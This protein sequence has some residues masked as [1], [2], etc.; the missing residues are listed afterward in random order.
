[1]CGWNNRITTGEQWIRKSANDQS[2]PV[3]PNVDGKNN[4]NGHYLIVN[5]RTI[6]TFF[7]VASIRSN[8]AVLNQFKRAYQS[9]QM[10]FHYFIKSVTEPFFNIMIKS[11]ISSYNIIWRLRGDQGSQ[12]KTAIVSIYEQRRPF[13]IKIE[14]FSQG[15]AG[16][17]AIDDIG[18]QNCAP[19]AGTKT[20][21]CH[22]NQKRCQTNNVC[23][24]PY[25]F[26][27]GIDDCGDAFDEMAV[28]CNKIIVP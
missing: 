2:F 4:P 15:Q 9:C 3:G 5:P 6:G 27:D 21:V 8:T 24:D 26:C 22:P 28:N 7:S 16:L 19:P 25:V 13:N 17:I 12:W 14:G 11:G 23:I 18:F 20:G 1:M 10:T